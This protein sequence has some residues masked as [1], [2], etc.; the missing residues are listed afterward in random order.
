MNRMLTTIDETTG[1]LDRI[2]SEM[3]VWAKR[4]QAGELDEA[5]VQTLKHHAEDMALMAEYVQ[6]KVDVGMVTP[7][8]ILMGNHTFVGGPDTLV[9]GPYNW[10]VCV[11]CRLSKGNP[12]HDYDE[13]A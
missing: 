11:T 4:A 2:I 5:D 3:K 12:I 8:P 9:G 10:T 1:K 7:D 6:A 13:P